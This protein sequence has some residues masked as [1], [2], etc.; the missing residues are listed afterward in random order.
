[1]SIGQILNMTHDT[2][3]FPSPR[4]PPTFLRF[5]GTFYAFCDQ[6]EIK[7]TPNRSIKIRHL[8]L[9]VKHDKIGI[10]EI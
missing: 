3:N 6:A 9:N 1:M 4:P 10:Q 8:A 5:C 2:P 7:Q